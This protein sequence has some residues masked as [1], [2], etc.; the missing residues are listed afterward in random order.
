MEASDVMLF[1]HITSAVAAFTLSGAVHTAESQAAK[2]RT[3]GQMLSS[4]ATM[5]LAPLFGLFTLLLFLTG[6]GL[7]GMA[8]ENYSVGDAW[9][10][11][12]IVVLVFLFVVGPAYLAPHGKK[13]AGELVAAG[14]DAPVPPAARTE[15]LGGTWLVSWLNGFLA[16]GVVFNMVAKPDNLLACLAVIVVVG[17]IGLGIGQMTRNRQLAGGAAPA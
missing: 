9:V 6:M 2:A 4:M 16:L 3:S 12:G 11:T 17:G 13:M 1:A 10:W 8:D 14:L 15:L 7:V 5:K